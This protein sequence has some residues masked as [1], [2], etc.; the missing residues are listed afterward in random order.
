MRTFIVLA[1]MAATAPVGLTAQAPADSAE[2]RGTALNY[3]EGWYTGNADRMTRAL[4]PELVKRI[5]RT[6]STGHASIQQMGASS[7]IAGTRGGY[8]RQTPAA[9]QRK[10][11]KILDIFG[12]TASVRADMADWIDY[13][14]MAKFSGRWVIVNVL[15]EMKPAKK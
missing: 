15:W 7:L 11:V 14:H 3:V 13:L 12:N 5:I 6:D 1:V 10:D 2:I 8:G 4:H 9:R